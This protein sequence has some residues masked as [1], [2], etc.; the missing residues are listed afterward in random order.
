MDTG[1]NVLRDRANACSTMVLGQNDEVSIMQCTVG[2]HQVV[3]YV[4]WRNADIFF[5][6]QLFLDERT[7]CLKYSLH[8]DYPDT[9]LSGTIIHPA[10]GTRRE[11]IR[12]Q[13]SPVAS[14]IR[15]LNT[16]WSLAMAASGVSDESGRVSALEVCRVCKTDGD[17]VFQCALCLRGYHKACCELA[18]VGDREMPS[19]EVIGKIPV[20][21][22]PDLFLNRYAVCTLCEAILRNAVAPKVPALPAYD[23]DE[24]AAALFGDFSD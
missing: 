2:G 19:A 17:D 4:H 14:I 16:M 22:I 23:D 20:G 9:D 7:K 11:K 18:V 21:D 13:R 8:K 10:I 6:Q 5:G 24:A 3:T 15:S 1:L 12:D